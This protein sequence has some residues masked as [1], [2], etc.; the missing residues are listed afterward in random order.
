MKSSIS[1]C[2]ITTSPSSI[3]SLA[4]KIKLS[5]LIKTIHIDEAT[6]NANLKAKLARGKVTIYIKPIFKWGTSYK[7]V[8]NVENKDTAIQDDFIKELRAAG[9]PENHISSVIDVVD[10]KINEFI[11]ESP[12]EIDD[13]YMLEDTLGN[14]DLVR[15]SEGKTVALPDIPVNMDVKIESNNLMMN[16]I[17]AAADT[18]LVINDV[19]FDK[20]VIENVDIYSEIVMPFQASTIEQSSINPLVVN[21]L[22]VPDVTNSFS[23]DKIISPKLDFQLETNTVSSDISLP[24][25]IDMNP[26][27]RMEIKQKILWKNL[28]I[29]VEFGFVFKVSMNYSL[30]VERSLIAVELKNIAINGI[31]SSMSMFGTVISNAK[32]GLIQ[33][34]KLLTK[35]I[36]G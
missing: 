25:I 17:D 1:L 27:K 19:C 4:S 36:S 18:S 20:S 16:N 7:G 23:I 24:N 6:G 3:K 29:W 10:K 15:G 21:S 11:L 8:E 32:L 5:S 34:A 26:V 13:E 14:I 28:V 31:E 9:I 30:L 33:I 2:N 22:N 35:N 12:K